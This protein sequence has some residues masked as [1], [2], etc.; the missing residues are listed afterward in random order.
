MIT[1]ADL[2]KKGWTKPEHM[3]YVVEELRRSDESYE[4]KK[5]VAIAWARRAN[6]V[7]EPWMVTKQKLVVA[8][9][10]A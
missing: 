2:T 7:L 9:E 5:D 10:V 6:L 1:V 4:E 3:V 8:Q